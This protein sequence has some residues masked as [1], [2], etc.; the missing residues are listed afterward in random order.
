MLDVKFPRNV[1]LWFGTSMK[2]PAK[3]L[4]K[5]NGLELLITIMILSIT[6]MKVVIEIIYLLLIFKFENLKIRN[7]IY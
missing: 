2:A 1:D 5:S 7:F 6:K 3:N 4:L